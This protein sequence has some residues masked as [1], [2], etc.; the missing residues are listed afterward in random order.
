MHAIQGWQRLNRFT[1]GAEMN[2]LRPLL[3][4][5]MVELNRLFKL[6]FQLSFKTFGLRYQT[7]LT[8]VLKTL[9]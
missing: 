3:S 7:I 4:V 5:L 8:I 6:T 1:I 9:N 2:R